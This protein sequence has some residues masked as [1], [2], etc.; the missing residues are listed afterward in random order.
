M[1]FKQ[2]LTEM[3]DA[4]TGGKAFEKVFM[5]ACDLIG[6]QYEKNGVNGRGWDIK[7][8]G[9]GWTRI[10]SSMD[11][12]IKVANTKWLFS[13]T[14][15]TNIV[16]WDGIDDNY[17][18][19]SVINRIKDIFKRIG[20]PQTVFL[21]P[22]TDAIQDKITDAVKGKDIIEL[23]KIFVSNNFYAEKLGR[24]YNIRISVHDDGKIGSIAID[25]SGKVFMRSERPRKLG[26]SVSVTFRTPT[27]KL[28]KTERP[29]KLR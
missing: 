22:K 19:K 8:I 2:Y 29:I 27:P 6:L 21:K 25:K 7:P 15:L 9:D 17:D 5:G 28:N 12:N 14:E 1:K 20:L 13:S 24:N 10:I 16:P 23:E 11:V 3:E 18:E 26:G 4:G